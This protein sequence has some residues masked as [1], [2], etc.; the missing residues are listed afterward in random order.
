MFD[1]D[2]L[3]DIQ[4]YFIEL[5]TDLQWFLKFGWKIT[6]FSFNIYLII[7]KERKFTLAWKKLA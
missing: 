7:H 3:S 2:F 4:H 6:E 1:S 5:H